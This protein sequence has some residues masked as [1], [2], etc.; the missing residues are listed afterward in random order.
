MANKKYILGVYEDDEDVL[1][2]VSDVR[3][4]GIKIHE[5]YSPFAIHGLDTAL[6]YSRARMGVPAFMF[7]I[8]GTSLAFLL[9]FWTMGWDWPM[10]IGGK[11]F[12][13]FPTNIPIVFEL[14]VLLAA[15]GMSFVFF[16]MESLYPG[17]KPVIFDERITDDKF[18]MAIDLEKSGASEEDVMEALKASGAAEV[19]VKEI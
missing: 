7:G 15:Y 2:A 11:N 14:T 5:V 1:H 19:N 16:G 4:K 13:P 6:G 17:S 3:G 10:I 12:V 9:T 8:T 18:V